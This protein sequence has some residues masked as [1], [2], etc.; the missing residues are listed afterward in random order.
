MF[1]VWRH[2]SRP[3]IHVIQNNITRILMLNKFI[4][5]NSRDMS[6]AKF[7]SMA[8]EYLKENKNECK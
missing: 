4:G 1:K 5:S 2:T 3:L 8:I 6:V 7:D